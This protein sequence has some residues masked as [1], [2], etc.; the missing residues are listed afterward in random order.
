MSIETRGVLRLGGANG[1]QY[2]APLATHHAWY[3][4]ATQVDEYEDDAQHFQ[5]Y[6]DAAEYARQALEYGVQHV[7]ISKV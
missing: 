7:T 1:P 4:V 5:Y 3:L 6:A 2:V